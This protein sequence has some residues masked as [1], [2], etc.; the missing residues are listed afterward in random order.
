MGK[1]SNFERRDADYYPTPQKPMLPLIPFL[2]H[3]GVRTFAEPCCGNGALVRHLEAF[4]L[5]WREFTR[6]LFYEVA[7]GCSGC[8]AASI[9]VLEA[10][11]DIDVTGT[12][13]YL[14]KHDAVCDCTVLCGM[15]VMSTKEMSS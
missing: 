5:R 1:R 3:D 2:R 15:T 6:L 11:G 13:E 8:F 7:D 14:E 4:G 12:I 9:K 10:M